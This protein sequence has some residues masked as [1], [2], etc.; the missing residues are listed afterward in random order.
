MPSLLFLAVK[1]IMD[2]LLKQGPNFPAYF[3]RSSSGVPD[4]TPSVITNS[5]DLDKSLA[6]CS[7]SPEPAEV[8]K[9]INTTD[10]LLYMYTSGTTGLPKAV[11]ISHLR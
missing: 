2:D 3:T 6:K 7:K 9:S 10:P 1:E 4:S 8:R 5:V 11:N